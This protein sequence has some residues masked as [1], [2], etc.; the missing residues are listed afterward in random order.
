MNQ[1]FES[2]KI[3]KIV[4]ENLIDLLIENILCYKV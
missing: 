4:F 2:N 3:I 1:I